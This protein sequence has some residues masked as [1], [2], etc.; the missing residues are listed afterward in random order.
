MCCLAE[1][2]T[3]ICKCAHAHT[4]AGQTV[5]WSYFCIYVYMIWFIRFVQRHTICRFVYLSVCLSA[6]LFA[7]VCDCVLLRAVVLPHSSL[8]SLSHPPSLRL[9]PTRAVSCARA[10]GKFN[11]LLLIS[12]FVFCAP[13]LYSYLL[14]GI[15]NWYIYIANLRTHTCADC[16]EY[17][18][19]WVCEMGI[20]W[21]FGFAI[22]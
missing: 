6:W 22:R 4:H 3:Y 19:L 2:H 12:S 17:V 5:S 9:S 14:Y 21:A 10:V 1:T 18:C 16:T 15:L 11:Y 7:W 8:L 20:W 13:L